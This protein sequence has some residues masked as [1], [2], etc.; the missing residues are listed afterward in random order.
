MLLA[1]N[2]GELANFRSSARTMTRSTNDATCATTERESNEYTRIAPGQGPRRRRSLRILPLVLIASVVIS[3]VG[4]ITRSKLIAP[5]LQQ[6][7][8]ARAPASNHLAAT[9]TFA[10]ENKVAAASDFIPNTPAQGRLI[11]RLR[12]PTS[13]QPSTPTDRKRYAYMFYATCD[14]YACAALQAMDHLVN[15]LDMDT[16]AIEL[17]MLHTDGVNRYLLDKMTSHLDARTIRVDSIYADALDPTWFLSLTKLRT[18]QEWGY[19]R[20]VYLDAD[21]FPLANLDHL[22]D[23]PPGRLYAP[24]AYWLPQPFVSTSLMAIEPNNSVFDE[25]IDWT[26]ARGADA[27]YDMDVINSFFAASVVHLSGVYTILNS[28]FR[29]APNAQSPIFR[30]TAELK[31]YGML[32]HFSCMPDG[33]YGKPWHWP[34]HNLS[35]LDGADFDPLFG[36]M[37][38]DYW[39]GERELCSL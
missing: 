20:V 1:G 35:L 14:T 4:W 18:F 6:A 28:D 25:L 8:L 10:E 33:E 37:Y 16:T 31:K 26:R 27:G 12:V 34:S 32:V 13:L 30:T 17:V 29:R 24:T 9:Q 5:A 15:R 36:E 21:S 19:D 39:R 7:T 11:S 2:G 22:F 38:E 3:V 23:L